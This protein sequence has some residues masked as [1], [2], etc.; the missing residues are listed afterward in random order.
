MNVLAFEIMP[1]ESSNDHQVRIRVDGSDWLG[2]DYLGVDPPCFF[3]QSSLIAGGRLLVGRCVCGCEG[4]DDVWVDVQRGEH[5]VLWANAKGLCLHF[6]LETYENMIVSARQDFSWEDTKRTAERLVSGTLEGMLID[7]G[8]TFD[9]ASARVHD[10]IITLSFSK[11]GT[12]KLIEFIWDGHSPEDALRGA[13]RF[14]K[15]RVEIAG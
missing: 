10:G 12:Q 7:D 1:S 2:E 5:E 4:C 9:W 8:Y 11:S 3:A 13:K 6:N 14:H 15:E